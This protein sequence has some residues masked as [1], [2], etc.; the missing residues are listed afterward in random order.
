MVFDVDMEFDP[1]PEEILG[2]VPGR[3]MEQE[4]LRA[5]EEAA[6]LTR[7]TMNLA[8]PFGG[9]GLTAESWQL[10]NAHEERPRRFVGGAVTSNVAAIVLEKGARYSGVKRPP[11]SRLAVWVR[12]KLGITEEKA[13]KSASE[14]ISR[15]IAKRGLP[16]PDREKGIFKKAF[17]E[18]EPPI[19]AI[20]NRA[21]ARIAER[22]AGG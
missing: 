22:I 21:A 7:N 14:A 9:T 16:A 15:A 13:V 10:V 11:P 1:I 4:S 5:I 20:M 2:V 18:I 8:T 19:T 3:I 17:K 6:V 12:R